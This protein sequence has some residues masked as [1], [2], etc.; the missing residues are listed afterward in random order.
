MGA[1]KGRVEDTGKREVTG[2][3]WRAW[4]PEPE[5]KG[6]VDIDSGGSCGRLSEGLASGL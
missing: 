4:A 3:G 1:V 6:K 5:L 2:E